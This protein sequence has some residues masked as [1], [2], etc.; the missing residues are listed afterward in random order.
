MKYIYLCVCMCMCALDLVVL[1]VCGGRGGVLGFFL[2]VV[3]M[4][5]FGVFFRIDFGWL[6]YFIVWFLFV[7]V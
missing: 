3:G 2:F 4:F 6:F 7:F 5:I 1:F